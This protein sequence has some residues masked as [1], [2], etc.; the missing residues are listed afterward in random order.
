VALDG[1]SDVAGIADSLGLERFAVWG[2]SGGGK[3]ALACA[4]AL[5]GRVVAA[6][7][8][9]TGAPYKAE[10]LDWFFGM[11]EF[12]VQDFKLMLS[13]QSEWVKKSRQDAEVMMRASR[14]EL[15]QL[16]GSLISDADRVILTDEL[17]GFLRAQLRDGFKAGFD[18]YI[19]DGLA[20]AKPWGF[21]PISVK[22]PVQVWHGRQDR[23]VPF[24]HGQ[25]LA[26]R[27]PQADVH[28]EQDE[29]HLTLVVR[30]V[31][32]IHRWLATKF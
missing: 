12:N 22:V 27:M 11:G 1:A 15:L 18:G 20:D 4:A 3:Y 19:D 9:S 7:S 28:L 5:P 16:I 10:G 2:H 26:E 24:A 17:V 23:F 31:P 6:A 32:E 25:W 8:L 30:R 21:D 13:N 14:E 29:G